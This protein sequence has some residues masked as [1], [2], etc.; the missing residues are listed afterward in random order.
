MKKLLL[1][2]AM[3]A[4]LVAPAA[5]ADV[6]LIRGKGREAAR[7]L[8]DPV[9]SRKGEESVMR[10]VRRPNA[11]YRVREHLAEAEEG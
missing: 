5:A 7:F 1:A 4:A 9:S 11:E 2:T 3:V 8:K 6:D 10:P